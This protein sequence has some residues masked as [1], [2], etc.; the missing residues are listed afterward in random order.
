MND[1]L[2]EYRASYDLTTLLFLKKF[3]LDDYF[4]RPIWE[5]PSLYYQREVNCVNN[6]DR[7]E[8]KECP[9][10]KSTEI[11]EHHIRKRSVFGPN[12]FVVYVCRKCHGRLEA[13]V[14]RGEAWALTNRIDEF[15]TNIDQRVMALSGSK[16][17]IIADKSKLV[18]IGGEI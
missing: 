8:P 14:A 13:I 10:C 11:T 9:I 17:P 12:N 18:K 2:R 5:N 6:A 16:F 4:L 7:L 3:S 15:R 1:I